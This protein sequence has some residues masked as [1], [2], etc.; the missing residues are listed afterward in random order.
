MSSLAFVIELPKLSISQIPLVRM[1]AR[2]HHMEN[3]MLAYILQDLGML[4][5]GKD[6]V[7]LPSRPVVA[8]V[9]PGVA[10]IH[11]AVAAVVQVMGT[12]TWP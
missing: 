11:L 8:M 1:L 12:G 6:R 3:S 4:S 7:T 2:S 9:H 10:T 5:I